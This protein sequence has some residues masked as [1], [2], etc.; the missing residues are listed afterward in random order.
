MIKS[1]AVIFFACIIAACSAEKGDIT[2]PL[3]YQKFLTTV[4]PEFMITPS[5]ALAWHQYKDKFGPTYSGNKSWHKFL[6]L[7]KKKLKALG[8]K[9]LAYNKWT[10]DRWHTSDWPDG[11]KW[12]LKSDGRP[13]Q[14]AHYGAYSGATG[15]EGITA[16][17]ALFNPGAEM[18]TYADKIVVV[19]VAPHPNPPLKRRLQEMVHLK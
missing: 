12:S 15:A 10:Y 11:S 3:E 13:V 19:P 2:Q 6:S 16:E 5:E 7:T 18:S 17:L 8:V 4:N 9:D 1:A 14:V